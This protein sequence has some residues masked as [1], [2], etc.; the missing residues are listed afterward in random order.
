MRL[1]CQVQLEVFK[2]LVEFMGMGLSE[3]EDEDIVCVVCNGDVFLYF[4]E[5]QLGDFLRGVVI[6]C[7]VVEL[8]IGK[9][10]EGLF[11]MGMDYSFI[12]G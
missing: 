7:R 9:F 12:M 4:L 8:I 5:M 2:V 3:N 11:L 1:S 6:W 10:F